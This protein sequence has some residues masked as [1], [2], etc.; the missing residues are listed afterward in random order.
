MKNSS[1]SKTTAR[2]K[3]IKRLP[4]PVS[5]ALVTKVP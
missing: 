2:Q 3:T 4:T 5:V 1:K